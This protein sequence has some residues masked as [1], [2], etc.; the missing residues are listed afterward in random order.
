MGKLAQPF[1]A[2]CIDLFRRQ[3]S[4]DIL[5]LFHLR[6]RLHA[7]VQ[8]LIFD[9]VPAHL[10][11]RIFMPIEIKTSVVGEVAAELQEEWA[12][13][14][15][16][17]VKVVVVH[18]SGR[19]HNPG[20]AFASSTIGPFLGPKHRRLFLSFANEHDPFLPV[21]LRAIRCLAISS[22]RSPLPN[23]TT[24]IWWSSTKLS[25]AETNF[26]LIGRINAVEATACFRWYLKNPTAPV[27]C[28]KPGT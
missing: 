17:T 9:F 18:H 23:S 6:A 2:E 8:R 13:I 28:C 10:S 16:H 4:A 5:Q 26:S 3:A 25:I 22:L 24:G 20:I 27:T 11:F 21:E 15:I 12:K 14:L 1:A 19:T 7:I